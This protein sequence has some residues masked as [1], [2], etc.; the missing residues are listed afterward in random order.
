MDSKT[1]IEKMKSPKSD[2]LETVPGTM[3]CVGSL[4]T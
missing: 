2:Y 3:V 1:Y 4:G